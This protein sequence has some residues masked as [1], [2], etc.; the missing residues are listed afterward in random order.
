MYLAHLPLVWMLQVWAMRWAMPWQV[1]YPLILVVTVGV[2]LLLYHWLVRGTWVG[3][4][5]N[6]RRLPAR[7]GAGDPQGAATG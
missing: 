4:L 3:W 7:T 5:L 1:E 2:L 6:G